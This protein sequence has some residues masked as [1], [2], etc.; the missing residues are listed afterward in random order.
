MAALQDGGWMSDYDAFPLELDGTQGLE[1][2]KAPV[3]T[4]YS[5]HVPCLI[6]AS[7]EEWDRILHLMLDSLPEDHGRTATDMQSLIKIGKDIGVEEA[8]M[9]WKDETYRTFGYRRNEN[10]ELEVKCD[11][12]VG[13]KVAHLSHRGTT[14]AWKQ[15]TY[16]EIDRELGPMNGRGEAA[17]VFVNDYNAQ[18]LRLNVDD[19]D[20]TMRRPMS[21]HG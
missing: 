3:F 8:G 17:R 11:E 19:Q 15:K 14:D 12:L 16:P 10:D 18:C 2:A 9:I 21:W 6:H 5:N 13:M 7:R 1:L 4:S 20:N